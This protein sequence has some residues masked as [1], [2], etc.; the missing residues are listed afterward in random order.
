MSLIELERKC[1]C[2]ALLKVVICAPETETALP[3][4]ISGY[5]LHNCGKAKKENLIGPPVEV[6]AL[7][8]DGWQPV[9]MARN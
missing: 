4:F 8:S 3:N 2:G 5:L 7:T 6:F 1:E 9:G